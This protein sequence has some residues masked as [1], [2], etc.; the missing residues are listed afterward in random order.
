M[1]VSKASVGKAG[2]VQLG[3]CTAL[4]AGAEPGSV[5]H[6]CSPSAFS[7]LLFEITQLV[8]AFLFPSKLHL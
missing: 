6:L 3:E 7:S 2:K 4:G 1:H 8:K 5:D